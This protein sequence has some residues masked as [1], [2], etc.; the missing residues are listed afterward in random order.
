MADWPLPP[1]PSTA[2][3]TGMH[4][5]RVGGIPTEMVQSG[6]AGLQVNFKIQP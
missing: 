1:L 5:G 4:A 6:F 3:V 2:I